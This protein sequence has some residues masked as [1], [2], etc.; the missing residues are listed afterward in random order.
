MPVPHIFAA[1]TGAPTSDLDDNFAACLVLSDANT[2][3]DQLNFAPSVPLTSASTVNIGAA[4]SNNI[5]ING[6]TT[7]NAFDTIAEGALRL[8]TFTGTPMITYNV[9]SMQLIGGASRTMA[10]GD[11]SLF[12]SLGGGNWKELVYQFSS[13]VFPGTA[14]ASLPSIDCT[15]AGGALTFSAVAQYMAFRNASLTNGT[16]SVIN[17]APSNLVLPSGG[18][19]GVPTTTSGRI[20]LV[21]MN[22]AGTAE[23]AIAN[24]AG[25]LQMDETNLI[26]TTA[27]SASATANNVWYSTT[28]R[29]NLP[30][31]VIGAFDAVNT[32]GAW[33][34]PTA[35]IN[36]GGNALTAMGSIG[37]GQIDSAPTY[38]TGTTYYNGAKPIIIVRVCQASANEAYTTLSLNGGTARRIGR[39]NPGGAS[40]TWC[41]TAVCI[42]PPFASFKFVE[43]TATVE[44]NWQLS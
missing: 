9:T 35:E 44:F 43:T 29:S 25:G 5:T 3:A 22:N 11:V 2:L 24:I 31:R 38:N 36:A 12:R 20:V 26:S 34:D 23:L 42:I 13:G 30:Y 17:A 32:T 4:A 18:T 40:T 19:L 6:N 10:A 16:P 27:I 33:S 1:G 8:L 39:Q 14:P 15:Q 41:Y 7:I 37:Y 28:A 21:E